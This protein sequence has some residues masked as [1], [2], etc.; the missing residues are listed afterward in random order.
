MTLLGILIAW[1]RE[2]PTPPERSY[3]ARVVS[4]FRACFGCR[5]PLCGRQAHGLRMPPLPEAVICS[6]AR[7]RRVISRWCSGEA[8]QPY[9]LRP[10]LFL[11]LLH[12]MFLVVGDSLCK[13]HRTRHAD[14]SKRDNECSSCF[15][16]ASH[17]AHDATFVTGV[18]QIPDAVHPIRVGKIF[19]FKMV[20]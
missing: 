5:T 19:V 8:S 4:C 12:S 18:R 11:E 15:L 13:R 10:A 16:R 1:P 14:I 9:D 6:R 3:S 17:M 20:N 7:R 2:M